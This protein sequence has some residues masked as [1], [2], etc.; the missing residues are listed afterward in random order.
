MNLKLNVYPPCDGMHG[1]DYPNRLA[2]ISNFPTKATRAKLF[3]PVHSTFP[4]RAPKKFNLTPRFSPI[5]FSYKWKPSDVPA[6]PTYSSQSFVP[7][8]TEVF[9]KI[10]KKIL[11]G[12]EMGFDKILQGWEAEKCNALYVLTR[13]YVG[14]CRFEYVRYPGGRLAP[15]V[16]R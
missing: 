10:L 4:L 3:R 9:R 1:K 14:Y 12:C 13:N 16:I 2:G 15:V 7:Q 8:P 11:A 6:W 5:T